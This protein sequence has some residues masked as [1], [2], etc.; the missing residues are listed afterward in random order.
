[1]ILQSERLTLKEVSWDDLENIHLFHSIPEVDE[2]N[3]LGIPTN[4]E[5]TRKVVKDI[6]DAQKISPQKSYHWNII[7]KNTQ[8]FI[9]M[10][11][12]SLSFDKYRI[13]EIY[14]KL[15]PIHWNKGYATEVSK[16]LIKFGF[17][18]F[19]LHRI[20]AGAAVENKNSIKV[21]KK[22]GMSYE[23]LRRKILPIRGNW[24]DNFEYAIVEDDIRDY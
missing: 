22:S 11:G 9:G 19:N 24:V 23:G 17:E 5:D 21:L 18:D 20:E 1:M 16:R 14:Y 8:E 4:L 15:M 10:A 13:G 2:Y 7:L 12:M 6:I 3:T